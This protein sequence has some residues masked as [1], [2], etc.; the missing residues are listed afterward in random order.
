MNGICL[1]FV[2]K[3][4]SS[5]PLSCG[6]GLTLYHTIPTLND[7]EKKPFESIVG[8]GENNG[9]QHFLLLLQ[10]F[11]SIS[12]RISAFKF[13]LFCGLQNALNLEQS[14]KMSFGKW[15]NPILSEYSL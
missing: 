13:Y 7:S 9:N 14:K 5:W 11:P 4:L 8:K 1:Y 3:H 10:C 6:K 2:K 12:K 15:V